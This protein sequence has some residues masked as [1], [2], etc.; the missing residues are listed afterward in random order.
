MT[1]VHAPARSTHPPAANQYGLQRRREPEIAG[2]RPETL[3]EMA[4]LLVERRGDGIRVEELTDFDDPDTD[5]FATDGLLPGPHALLA[6]PTF[7][8]RLDSAA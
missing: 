7:K 8:E 5:L 2:P 1:R 3:V 4:R 6:G